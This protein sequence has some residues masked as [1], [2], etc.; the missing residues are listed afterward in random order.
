MRGRAHRRAFA[1]VLIATGLVLASPG[2]APA[3]VEDQRA[4]LPPPAA[5]HDPVEGLWK[6]HQFDPRLGWW[7]I[8]LL[9]IHRVPGHPKLLTGTIRNETWDGDAKH[10]EPP[11]R[12]QPSESRTVIGMNARGTVTPD[13]HIEYWGIA[14]WRVERVLCDTG[15]VGYNLDHFSGVIDHARQEFQFVNNDGGIAVNDPTVFRRIRCF[16]GAP[17]PHVTTHPPPFFPARRSGCGSGW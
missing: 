6:S 5:C 13:G 10:D 8:F 16:D 1:I 7:T 17:T 14:P 9:E 2:P 11:P 12:C 4:R 15:P 3:T